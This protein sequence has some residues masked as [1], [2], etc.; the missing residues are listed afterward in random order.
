[1]DIKTLFE[2]QENAF[3]QRDRWFFHQTG[4]VSQRDVLSLATYADISAVDRFLVVMH[5]KVLSGL[6]SFRVFLRK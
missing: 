4:A 1:M 2:W 6:D 3:G 5:V